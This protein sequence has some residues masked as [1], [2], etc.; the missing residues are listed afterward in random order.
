MEGMEPNMNC[1]IMY[2]VRIRVKVEESG[3]VPNEI[4]I[5][6]HVGQYGYV[7]LCAEGDGHH[8]E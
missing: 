8:T 5:G 2:R 3:F 6:L 7:D 4:N 1:T